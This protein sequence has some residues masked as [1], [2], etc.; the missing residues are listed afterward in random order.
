MRAQLKRATQ[1]Y[2]SLSL[3]KISFPSLMQPLEKE[4]QV[5]SG[6]RVNGLLTENSIDLEVNVKL[7]DTKSESMKSSSVDQE[8]RKSGLLRSSYSAPNLC[9][10]ND[11]DADEQEKPASKDLHEIKKPDALVIPDDYLCP[12]SLELMRD[13]VIVATG[14]VW[15]V[16]MPFKTSFFIFP[17]NFC[18]GKSIAN[19][20]DH[21]QA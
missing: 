18:P 3:K 13:P 8:T 20:F 5:E 12:I 9:A 1:R 6:K 11:N 15:F 4:I 21:L 16:E 7:D 10:T 19:N 17:S 2:G 14:Q